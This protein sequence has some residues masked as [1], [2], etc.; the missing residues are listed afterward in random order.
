[1]EPIKSEEGEI[2]DIELEED[3]LRR[4]R[5][6]AQ[7]NQ[8]LLEQHGI[9]AVDVMGSVGSGKTTELGLLPEMLPPPLTLKESLKKE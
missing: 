6:L 3:L 4:N 8:K 9:L 1:M 2:L 5:Q 7:E